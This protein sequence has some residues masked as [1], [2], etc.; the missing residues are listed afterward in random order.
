MAPVPTHLEPFLLFDKYENLRL[1]IRSV[2]ILDLPSDFPAI[3]T[4]AALKDLV[5]HGSLWVARTGACKL[6]L[7]TNVH[8]ESDG[9]Y[10]FAA[11]LERSAWVFGHLALWS[12]L[13]LRL[14]REDDV[15]LPSNVAVFRL[16][17]PSLH[18]SLLPPEGAQVAGFE[19]LTCSLDFEHNSDEEFHRISRA[20]VSASRKRKGER[21]REVPTLVCQSTEQDDEL[22]VQKPPSGLVSSIHPTT[23]QVL[24]RLLGK[25][26]LERLVEVGIM[27]LVTGQL[28]AVFHMDYLD[29]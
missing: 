26:S 23:V 2:I 9:K 21:V 6:E 4:S 12:Q 5:C 20:S 29:V 28:P 19:R 1:K 11:V 15:S 13:G 16:Y 10:V 7:H 8:V 27:A 14:A 25:S 17:H 3:P 24:D 22:G 18:S